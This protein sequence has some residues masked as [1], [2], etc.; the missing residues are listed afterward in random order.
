MTA[1]E[2]ELRGLTTR[3]RFFAELVAEGYSDKEIAKI[4]H[5]STSTVASTMQVITRTLGL[6]R[7]RNLRVQLAWLVI[8]DRHLSDPN[9]R[10]KLPTRQ[11][12]FDASAVVAESEKRRRDARLANLEKANAVNPKKQNAA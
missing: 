5:I 4:M 11:Q 9:Y 12:E 2:Y 1:N 6:D 7:T 8:H 10:H 3:Q